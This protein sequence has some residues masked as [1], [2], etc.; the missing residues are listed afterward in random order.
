MF[1]VIEGPDGSGKTTLA[2]ALADRWKGMY[3]FEPT[4]EPLGSLARWYAKEGRYEEAL[5]GFLADRFQHIEEVVAP[6]LAEGQVVI[7]D[8]YMIST[9]VY[10]LIPG[11]PFAEWKDALPGFVRSLPAWLEPHLTF[12][13]NVPLALLEQRRPDDS[14]VKW[15]SER[16][17]H[18][19]YVGGKR[20]RQMDE[21]DFGDAGE[22]M[23][24]NI[25]TIEK[26]VKVRHPLLAEHL[27]I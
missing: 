9:L 25:E 16:Y 4:D 19:C 15:A 7:C 11:A 26:V 14:S 17:R 18:F 13:L 8:R 5:R 3:T 20:L 6:A 10:Q 21:R 22:I 23:Q 2:R 27:G 12:V 1:I 24:A